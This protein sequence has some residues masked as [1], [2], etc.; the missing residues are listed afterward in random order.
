MLKALCIIGSG[1][2]AREVACLAADAGRTVHAFLDMSEKEAINGIPVR[3]LNYLNPD[4]HQVVVA[5]GNPLLRRKIVEY[6]LPA[7]VQHATLIHPSV[8]RSD[9]VRIG[10]GSILCAGI[11]LTCDIILGKFTHLNLHSTIGHDVE[12]GA[13]F[14]TAPG[15]HISGNVKIGECVYFGTNSSTVEKLTIA[16]NVVVGA[17]ACVV[18][19][20]TEAGTY[21]GV[22][23]KKL[24]K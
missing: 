5:V 8:I 19:N 15:V 6:E 17:S 24:N 22:P 3:P 20:L 13:Y 4:L 16:D 12:T 11:I 10:E 23:A 14:T 9:T 18:N 21:V 2:F 7:G 1:G